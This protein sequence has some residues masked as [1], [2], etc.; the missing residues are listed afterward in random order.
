[1]GLRP[2]FLHQSNKSL[3]FGAPNQKMIHVN[4]QM[5]FNQGY[6]RRNVN[7]VLTS[8]GSEIRSKGVTEINCYITPNQSMGIKMGVMHI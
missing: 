8:L 5:D 4:N 7:Y 3:S 2:V 6:Y 1:M